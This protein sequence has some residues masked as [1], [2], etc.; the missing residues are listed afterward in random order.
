MVQVERV[1]MNVESVNYPLVYIGIGNPVLY[2]IYQSDNN[3]HKTHSEYVT[4]DLGLF[5]NTWYV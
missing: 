2:K 5:Y 4:E 1:G 3:T